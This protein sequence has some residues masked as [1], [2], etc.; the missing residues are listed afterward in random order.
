MYRARLTAA[1]ALSVAIPL[2]GIGAW[3]FNPDSGA[4]L[5][6]EVLW[7]IF[8]LMFEVGLFLLVA[9]VVA[10]GIFTAVRKM[11]ALGRSGRA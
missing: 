6:S 7:R 1:V 10:L 9:L 11:V 8:G 2:G 4:V 3:A 5:H